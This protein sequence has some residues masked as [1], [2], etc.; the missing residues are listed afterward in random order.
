MSSNQLLSGILV[1]TDCAH[2]KG[3]VPCAPHKESGVH[4]EDCTHY[5]PKDRAILIIKLGAIG[6]V[7][8]TTPLLLRVMR[9]YPTAEIWWLTQTPEVIPAVV[10]RAFPFTLESLLVIQS[11]Q[12]DT[13]INLDKASEACAL[14]K[15]VSARQKFGFTLQNGKPAPVDER[16]EK[17]F[18]T[19]IFDDFSKR[20]VKS[21]VEEI[22]EICGWKFEG[23]EYILD[24]D[25]NL[26]WNISPDN[27]PLIGLNT[28][29]G[30]RWPS[31][32]WPD[33]RWEAL[34]KKLSAS[35]FRVLLLGHFPLK[36]FVSLVN[37][38]KAVVTVVTMALHIAI[39]L[40]KPVILINNIFNPNEF[41]LYG[42]GEIVQP[43]LPCQ[44]YYKPVCVNPDYKCIESVGVD[45][46]FEAINRAVGSQVNNFQEKRL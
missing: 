17:K 16:A 4:C 6:D 38:C 26:R 21:Y 19:G 42:R 3:D 39:G 32:Q 12:F 5:D 27:R 44:C 10:H 15:T 22:F 46:I 28:G 11:T 33:E 18:L 43:E 14:L 7:I 24:V 9:E 45:R 36:Q 23:E 25:T 2:F 13:V 8:R 1:H 20:N 40:K 35:G 29:S 31:R 37:E 34:A 30:G 41:E